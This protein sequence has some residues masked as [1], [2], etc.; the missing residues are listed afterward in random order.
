M[1]AYLTSHY[2]SVPRRDCRESEFRSPENNQ[3][4]TLEMGRGTLRVYVRVSL[5]LFPR[6]PTPSSLEP[7]TLAILGQTGHV[8]LVSLPGACN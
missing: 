1:R 4:Q 6:I 3:K 5:P 8:L 2:S 7:G